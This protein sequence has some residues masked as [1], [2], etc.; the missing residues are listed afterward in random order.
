MIPLFNYIDTTERF[1]VQA[2]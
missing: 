2:G 1:K